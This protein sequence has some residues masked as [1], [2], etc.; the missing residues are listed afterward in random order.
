MKELFKE[1]AL[2]NRKSVFEDQARIEFPKGEDQPF[3]LEVVLTPTI[4]PFR[5]ACIKFSFKLPANYPRSAP[6][7]KCLNRIFH[8]NVST[9][10]SV[11]FSMFSGDWN[12]S[13][14]LEHFINGLLWFLQNPNPDSALNSACSIRD[15]KEFEKAVRSAIVGLPI[16]GKVYDKIIMV[17]SSLPENVLVEFFRLM[18]ARNVSLRTMLADYTGTLP[19]LA[20]LRAVKGTDFDGEVIKVVGISSYTIGVRAKRLKADEKLIMKELIVRVGE[21]FV[22]A[23]VRG[24]TKISFARIAA[25]FDV[26]ESDCRLA[27]VIDIATKLKINHRAVPAFGH[28]PLF[29]ATLVEANVAAEPSVAVYTATGVPNMILKTTFAHMLPFIANARVASFLEPVVPAPAAAAVAP[30]TVPAAVAPVTV[31]ATTAPVT[32]AVALPVVA[33]AVIVAPAPVATVV[34]AEA[35]EPIAFFTAVEAQRVALAA[36]REALAA[37]AAL[38]DAEHEVLAAQ[39]QRLLSLLTLTPPTPT[40]PTAVAALARQQQRSPLSVST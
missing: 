35:T 9:T 23:L 30:V 33:P 6:A 16:H 40:A 28:G 37:Q 34:A 5:D 31:T 12:A 3:D 39:A 25:L 26:K 18:F 13:Y 8:P 15:P 32:V 7:V 10:G 1:F 36:E 27:S 24:P 14:R 17:D 11:C 2:I 20:W 19:E 29:N 22:L 4:G 21:N 38:I